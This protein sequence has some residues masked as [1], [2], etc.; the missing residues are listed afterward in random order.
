MSEPIPTTSGLSDLEL[1]VLDVFLAADGDA[2]AQLRAQVEAATVAS[3]T[4]SGV[5]FMTK[6]DI[7][8]RLR[9]PGR[10]D[11]ETLQ[12]VHGAHPALPGGAEF[13]VQVKSGRLNTIEGFC[14]AGMWPGDESH[15]SVELRP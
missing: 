11:D 5:G 9:I 12:V 14:Y 4:P 10:P 8:E 15:F 13:I 2:S 7:P 1:A 6:L 3:R